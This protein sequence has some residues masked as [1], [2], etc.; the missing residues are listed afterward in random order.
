MGT[1]T[2]ECILITLMKFIIICTS[3]I[4]V[5]TFA[6]SLY[7]IL[8]HSS[9]IINPSF[10]LFLLLLRNFVHVLMCQLLTSYF[11]IF[12]KVYTDKWKRKE[13]YFKLTAV[14]LSRHNFQLKQNVS[15]FFSKIFV[16]KLWFYDIFKLEI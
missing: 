15:N 4:L 14:S 16:Q 1:W 5:E 7:T 8:F 9:K 10:L 12:V 6:F 11:S 13:F 3:L 2:T